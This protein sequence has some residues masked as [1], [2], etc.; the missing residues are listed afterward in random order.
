[1][2]TQRAYALAVHGQPRATG[3]MDVRVRPTPENARRVAA[4]LRR[5]GA[6][7]EQFTEADFARP[8]LVAQLG[9]KPNRIDILTGIDGL[10][11]EEAWPNRLA[12][13]VEG[14]SIPVLGRADLI[15]NKRATGRTQDLADAEALEGGPGH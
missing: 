7:M 3:D 1:M 10:S 8:D 13:V 15:R 2:T 12:Q 4:A 6:P 11:F 14:L 5:F 9:V